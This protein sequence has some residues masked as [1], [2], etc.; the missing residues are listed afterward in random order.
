MQ[1]N[2]L[3]TKEFSE[4]IKKKIEENK[5]QNLLNNTNKPTIA[6]IKKE[7]SIYNNH[8]KTYNQNLIFINLID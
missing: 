8:V 3:L 1:N 6:S 2:Y 4:N 5:K 7:V